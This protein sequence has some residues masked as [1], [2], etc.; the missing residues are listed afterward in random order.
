MLR[1]FDFV[2]LFCLCVFFMLYV[3]I[4]VCVVCGV[5]MSLLCVAR[6]LFL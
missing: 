6:S 4:L 3:A 1:I 2:F 5:S